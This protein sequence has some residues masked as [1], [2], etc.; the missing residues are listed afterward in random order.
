MF[1]GQFSFDSFAWLAGRMNSKWWMMN[2]WMIRTLICEWNVCKSIKVQYRRDSI[3]YT[4]SL[5]R[6]LLS[7]GYFPTCHPLCKVWHVFFTVWMDAF[8][9][10]WGKKRTRCSEFNGYLYITFYCENVPY[11]WCVH[12]SPFCSKIL[13][14][15]PQLP[16]RQ[17]SLLSENPSNPSHRKPFSS[18]FY[19][20]KQQYVCTFCYTERWTQWV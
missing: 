15:G 14:C 11:P 3:S 12:P 5:I 16:S 6:E 19:F 13:T 4:S 18:N 8:F 2:K 9:P 7:S 1:S 17:S 10:L 20:R